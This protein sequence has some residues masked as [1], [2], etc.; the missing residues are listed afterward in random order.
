MDSIRLQL[1][2]SETGHVCA[3]IWLTTVTADTRLYVDIYPALYKPLKIAVSHGTVMQVIQTLQDQLNIFSMPAIIA[4]KMSVA[5]Q[6]LLDKYDFLRELWAPVCV[7]TLDQ[8]RNDSDSGV[9]EAAEQTW[10]QLCIDGLLVT[11]IR[12]VL[13]NKRIP[14]NHFV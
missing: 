8:D 2:V 6:V 4:Q 12:Y 11:C 3:T 10:L 9:R 13:H 7:D 14:V 1:D 5:Q